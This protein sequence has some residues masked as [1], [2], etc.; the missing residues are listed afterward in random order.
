MQNI[1]RAIFGVAAQTNHGGNVEIEFPKRLGQSVGRPILFLARNAGA[2]TEISH[3]L[4][5]GQ[6]DSTGAI[7]LGRRWI[8][9]RVGE[10]GDGKSRIHDR[11]HR[12]HRSAATGAVKTNQAFGI[13][14]RCRGQLREI[15]CAAMIVL[16][17]RVGH[18]FQ[19]GRRMIE[20]ARNLDL[21]FRMPRYGVIIN[22]DTAIGGDEL[23]I[24][25]QHQRI[26]FK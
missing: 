9:A 16:F 22:R 2:R 20:L 7:H 14:R 13:F 10:I 15:K 25:G 23:T 18:A 24:L 11:V 5:L 1:D 19:G 8:A 26:D 17:D 21:Q 6:N 3:Q 4:G 12:H